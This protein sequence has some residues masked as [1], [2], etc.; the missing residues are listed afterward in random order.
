MCLDININALCR[1]VLNCDKARNRSTIQ[2]WRD[3]GHTRMERSVVKNEITVIYTKTALQQVLYNVKV[4][5]FHLCP[6][7]PDPHYHPKPFDI[8]GGI[9]MRFMHI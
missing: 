9:G 4:M 6:L 7:I 8:Q 3:M 2:Y 1:V 5:P